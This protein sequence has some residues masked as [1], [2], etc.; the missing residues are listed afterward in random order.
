MMRKMPLFAITLL[1]TLTLGACETAQKVEQQIERDNTAV[2]QAFERAQNPAP[3]ANINPIQVKPGVWLG[4]EGVRMQHGTPLPVSLERSNGVTITDQ[5]ALRLIDLAEVITRETGVPV[6]VNTS[7]PTGTST[8]SQQASVANGVVAVANGNAPPAPGAYASTSSQV[9]GWRG[10]ALPVQYSGPLSSVLDQIA[11]RYGVDWE[12]QNGIIRIFRYRTR[13]FTLYALATTDSVN[14][15]MDAANSSSQ[16]SSSTEGT[17]MSTSAG[18]TTSKA[19]IDIWREVKD[20]IDAMLPNGSVAAL[21]PATGTIT[22]TATADTMPVIAAYIADQNQRLAQQITLDVQVLSLTLADTE[23]YAFDLNLMFSNLKGDGQNSFLDL[24]V[25][26]A[27]Q[28]VNSAAGAVSVAIANAPNGSSAANWNGSKAVIRALQQKGNVSEL[29]RAPV[30]TLNN[31]TTPVN[32]LQQIG[33]LKSVSTT[34][35]DATATSSLEPGV[36]RTGYSMSLL[37][38][39][40]SDG[41][42]LLQVAIGLSQLDD[43][44]SES[45]GGQT[46]RTPDISTQTTLNKVI[47]RN[48]STLVLAGFQQMAR[49]LDKTNGAQPLNWFVS[50]GGLNAEDKTKFLIILITPHILSTEMTWSSTLPPMVG[51]QG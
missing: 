10:P 18:A 8:N 49:R 36:V 31:Q 6:R 21:S 2:Q 29:I 12:Y 46:I 37:P 43:L 41:R 26:G 13:T 19:T 20:A 34:V 51:G 45:S 9:S 44:K 47:L 39:V 50:G 15:D 22:V 40:L 17:A 32:V 16:T 25:G 42:V 30:T 1:S 23:S 5:N 7:S 4:V 35:T 27:S 38:R 24:A 48:R 33:Y 3:L 14:F 28:A 11:T